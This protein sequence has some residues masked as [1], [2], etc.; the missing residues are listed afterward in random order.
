MNM[1]YKKLLFKVKRFFKVTKI[2]I[3][4][5]WVVFSVC[6]LL[7]VMLLFPSL[8]KRFPTYSILHA[9]LNLPHEF[10]VCGK[11]TNELIDKENLYVYVGGYNVKVNDDGY[12]ELE[13]LSS[14][15]EKIMFCILDEKEH[16]V[17]KSMLN[18]MDN[19][20][21]KYLIIKVY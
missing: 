19:E 5:S 11:I 4:S 21:E 16:I 2:N 8:F 7:M 18:Y 13:F 20:W 10:E 15:K 3:N 9:E 1:D 12:F 17:Y 14:C 6:I